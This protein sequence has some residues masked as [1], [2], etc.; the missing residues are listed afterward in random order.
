MG[1]DADDHRLSDGRPRHGVYRSI[2]NGQ[3]KRQ[4]ILV[5]RFAY[6]PAV[7]ILAALLTKLLHV[8]RNLYSR[9]SP[10]GFKLID[11]SKH[12]IRNS[13]GIKAEM[14]VK[15]MQVA[16]LAK[17][18]NADRINR[19]AIQRC[20]AMR[21]YVRSHPARSQSVDGGQPVG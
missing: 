7:S 4:T 8:H 6:L 12:G 21:G 2:T 15:I 14:P 10:S 11:G 3:Q 18:V 9:G 17:G 13:Y 16:R 19:R 1:C 5:W 20:P